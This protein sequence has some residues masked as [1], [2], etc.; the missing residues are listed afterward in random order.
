MRG[1]EHSSSP[2]AMTRR[3]LDATTERNRSHSVLFEA[4]KSPYNKSQESGGGPHFWDF[5]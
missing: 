2:L 5:L 3:D 4:V 1:R